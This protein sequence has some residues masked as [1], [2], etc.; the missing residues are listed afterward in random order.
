[1]KFTEFFWDF[2]GTLF[3]TYPR[4]NRAVQKSLHEMDIDVSL[5]ELLPVLKRS[6]GHVFRTFAPGREKEASGIY[7]SHAEDEGYESM[8]PYPG[9]E[10]I[11]QSVL[12][13]GGR[14]YLYTLRSATSLRALEHYGLMKYFTDFVTHE[15]G[16]PGKPAPD[17]LQYLM[18]KHGL[19]PENCVMIGD[20][21][22]DLN[23]GINS[24]M[25]CALFDP[26]H[27]YDDFDT[28]YRYTSLFEM[29]EDLVWEHQTKDLCI[30]DM[31]QLQLQLQALHPNWGAVNDPQKALKWLLWVVGEIGEVVDVAKKNSGKSLMEPGFARERL[32]EELTDVSMY[33]NDVLNCYGITA[34]EFSEAY[35]SKMQKNLHRN[36]DQEHKDRYGK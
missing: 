35:Y 6:L 33:F 23:S 1:M 26:D 2:D 27:F 24:G 28:P 12:E 15:N 21:D 5:E 34:E 13:H 30:S 10:R 17:A 20:R 3:D 14:N 16:F 8:Q 19:A 32:V 29:M 22:I 9:A 4:I 36:Y 25:S 11:L 7:H 18:G 31:L